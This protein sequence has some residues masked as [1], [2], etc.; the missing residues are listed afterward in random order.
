MRLKSK[1][2]A[3]HSIFSKVLSLLL[4]IPGGNQ[5]KGIDRVADDGAERTQKT[6]QS[7][8]SQGGYQHKYPFNSHFSGQI[9]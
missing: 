2:Q 9:F 4:R 7:V 1:R 5:D 3:L 8:A 6:S